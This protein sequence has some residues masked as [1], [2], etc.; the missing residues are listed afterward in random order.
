MQRFVAPAVDG[1][2]VKVREVDV[3]VSSAAVLATVIV[4]TSTA[5][6][7]ES[8]RAKPV[9]ESRSPLLCRQADVSKLYFAF[10][11]IGTDLSVKAGEGDPFLV[12][13]SADG[14]VSRT[15]SI[16]VGRRTFTV[17]LSGN[18]KGRDLQ[19]YNRDY[20]CLFKLEPLP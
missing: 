4:V 6:L 8:W 1:D 5:A 10:A 11:D 17:D 15:I 7:A 12:P 16:P 19:V 18:A 3:R 2:C 20:A 13:V 14:S 9:L